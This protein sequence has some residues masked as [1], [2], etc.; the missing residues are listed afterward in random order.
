MALDEY[1]PWNDDWYSLDGSDAEADAWS[2]EGGDERKVESLQLRVWHEEV[3]FIHHLRPA[4]FATSVPDVTGVDPYFWCW[5]HSKPGPAQRCPSC[6][7]IRGLTRWSIWYRAT[8][9]PV[10]PTGDYLWWQERRCVLCLAR[11]MI[12]ERRVL[13]FRIK[14]AA[15]VMQRW[16]RYCLYAPPSARMPQGGREFR[17]A[18][19]SFVQRTNEH[20]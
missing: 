4:P 10:T 13:A 6:D 2:A 14:R 5:V 12:R 16:W 8:E 3:M 18:E 15:R 11:R 9:I 1:P 7:C 19:T 20:R 17:R